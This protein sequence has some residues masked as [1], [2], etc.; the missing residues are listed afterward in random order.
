MQVANKQFENM[1]KFHKKKWGGVTTQETQN[2][3][4]QKKI[5]K[6][7]NSIKICYPSGHAVARLDG[8]MRCKPEGS[9][10]RFPMVS[11]QFFIDIIPAAL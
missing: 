2:C 5:Q 7:L 8:A 9:R 1:A 6:A 3:T 4:L 11:L 10:V